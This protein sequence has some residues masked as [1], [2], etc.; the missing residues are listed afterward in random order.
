MFFMANRSN[1]YR[2]TFREFKNSN[3]LK[4][5]EDIE[6]DSNINNNTDFFS[7]EDFYVIYIFFYEIDSDHDYRL[8]KEELSK[9]SNYALSRKT[10]ERIFSQSARPFAGGEAMSF[11]DFV[12]FIQCVEDKT[13]DQS[14]EFWFNIL[15]LDGNGVLTGYELFYF[16]EE[17]N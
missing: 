8:N 12:W 11:G 13:T 9:Y 3:I 4:S 15:D 16:F 7:Y 6:G 17:Q 10:I 1:N 2:M 5:L 14:T